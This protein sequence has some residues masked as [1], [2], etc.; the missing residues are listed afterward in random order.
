MPRIILFTV[1]VTILATG[2]SKDNIAINNYNCLFSMDKLNRL[3]AEDK[4]ANATEFRAQCLAKRL[5]PFND[6]YMRLRAE[7]MK[8][9]F[10]AYGEEDRNRIIKQCRKPLI[11]LTAQ[12]KQEASAVKDQKLLTMHK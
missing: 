7:E 8:C 11:K 12:W 6:E 2:C 10:D 9:T 4:I 5:G 3:E 1:P